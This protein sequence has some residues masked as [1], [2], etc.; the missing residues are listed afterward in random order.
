MNRKLALSVSAIV[1]IL[2]L[3]SCQ[4]GLNTVYY[5]AGLT[6][7]DVS[8][9]RFSLVS[10]DSIRIIPTNRQAEIDRLPANTRLIGEF[11]IPSG[12]ITDPMEVEF[13]NLVQMLSDTI[14]VSGDVDTLGIDK[15]AMLSMWQ[16]GGI[17]GAARFLNIS[18]VIFH[19]QSN[20][21]HSICLADDTSLKENPDAEGYYHLTLRHKAN[22]DPELYFADATYSF[23]L[24]GKYTA[25]GIKGLKI[26]FQD[27][28][29]EEKIPLN[30]KTIESPAVIKF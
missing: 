16:S 22:K 2:S 7:V 10:D 9:E 29:S 24:D 27:F 12:E 14:K 30:T 18:F 28:T 21:S 5:R 26:S 1:A 20:I 8:G 25:E 13:V 19:G 15:L 23:L 17:H 6:K 11:T 4:K 3:A